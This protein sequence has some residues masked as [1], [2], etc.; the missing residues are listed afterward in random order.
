MTE[1]I[2]ITNEEIDRS[3]AK[4]LLFRWIA[5]QGVVSGLLCLILCAMLYGGYYAMETAIPSHLKQI[6][7]GYERQTLEHTKQIDR[8]T[9]SQ[10]KEREAML[11]LIERR[12]AIEN[13]DTITGS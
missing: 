1:E 4:V 2:K 6:Q 11:R 13:T 3:S 5:G 8:I 9:V 12:V 7:D 10:D